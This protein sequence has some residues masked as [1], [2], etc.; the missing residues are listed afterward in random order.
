MRAS[1]K[2]AGLTQV[3]VSQG[4]GISQSALSK[5]ESARLIPSAP[6]WFAFCEIAGISPDS[7][8]LG[9]IERNKSAFLGR[10]EL[11]GGFR[12]PRQF[13]EFRGSKV[14][15]AM[16]FLLLFRET[17]GE[18]KL[19]HYLEGLK[20]DPDFFVDLDNQ[21]NLAFLLEIMKFLI[22]KGE[23]KAKDFSKMSKMVTRPTVHGG[24]LYKSYSDAEDAISRIKVLVANARQYECNFR[25]QI[26][27]EKS[28]SI[29]LSVE[30]EP[31]LEA[32]SY[33]N[34]STLGNALCVY[35]QH[36]FHEVSGCCGPGAALKLRELECHY[37][38]ASRCTYELRQAG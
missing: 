21:I 17:L 8:T 7:L 34:D 36:Y 19:I 29:V 28:A 16:P 20:L 4:L 2:R 9:Y 3:G 6:Q 1:R 32:F 37:K 35:K 10:G 11:E 25:Y 31:H 14:R 30:P 22:S 24:H 18:D 13:A 23:L 27:E 33:R 38:G 15:A 5:M 26:E 12:L